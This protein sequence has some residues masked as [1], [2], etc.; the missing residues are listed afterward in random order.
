MK[1]VAA[2]SGVCQATVSLA[3]RGHPSIPAKTREHI[4]REATRLGYRPNPLISAL[5]ASLKT[6]HPTRTNVT[7]AYLSTR[8]QMKLPQRF[9]LFTGAR[10]RAE[11]LGFELEVFSY[12]SADAEGASTRRL[13]S[14]LYARKV[15]GILLPPLESL[16][17][18]IDLNWRH[19]AVATCAY[20][21][22]SPNLHRVAV[23]HKHLV[24]TALGHLRELGYRKIG[25]VTM[26]NINVRTERYLELG[27]LLHLNETEPDFRVPPLFVKEQ[28]DKSPGPL[29]K[30]MAAWLRRYEPDAMLYLNVPIQDTLRE[31]GLQAGRD[32]GL[33]NLDLLKELS[34][35]SGMDQRWDQVGATLLDIV[36]GQLYHNERGI[37]E[38]PRLVLVD[39]C[40][41]P[42][43]TTRPPSAR[44]R[45]TTRKKGSKTAQGA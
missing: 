16:N 24:T 43:N 15:E 41:V 28:P 25:L 26:D 31:L 33:A 32:I 1:D 38:N 18:S 17:V 11:S 23:N 5:M 13:G 36:T 30:E 45:R 12:D 37:P 9:K 7:L 44:P 29:V 40:W 42:G 8:S 20:S 27:F 6:A 19:F 14:I 4:L 22:A 35:E 2:A 39:G 10:Q 21:L 3:L 34:A